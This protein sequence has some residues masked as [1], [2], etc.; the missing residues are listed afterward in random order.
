MTT[1]ANWY[2]AHQ[3]S[4]KRSEGKS[5]VGLVAY[6]TGQTLKDERSGTWC[7]RN[8]PGEV[9]A[10]G[11]VAPLNAPSRFTA[12]DK[13]SKIWNEIESSETRVNSIVAV[14]WNVAGSREFSETDHRVVAREIAKGLSQRYGVIVTFGI[15]KPTD[16]GDDRNW[17]YH[18]GH[19]MR[20]VGPDGIGEKAREIIAK[21]T[22]T[23]E[24]RWARGMIADALNTRLAKIGS[25][26]RVTHLSYAER[27][28]VQEPTKHLG[29]KQNMAELKGMLTPIGNH[30]REARERNEAYGA[31]QKTLGHAKANLEAQIHDL[32][33]ERLKRMRQGVHK[34]EV[35]EQQWNERDNAVRASLAEMA[36]SRESIAAFDHEYEEEQKRIAR[37]AASRSEETQ[38]RANRGDIPDANDRWAKAMHDSYN[39][40]VKPEESMAQAVGLEAEQFRKE[41]NAAREA[42]AKETDPAKKKMLEYGRQIAACDYMAIGAERCA[43]IAGF[44]VGKPDNEISNRDRDR[45]EQWREIGSKLR[46]D[47]TDL[48]ET[49]DK[50]VYE[51]V[52]AF[53]KDQSRGWQSMP[54]QWTQRTEE[55]DQFFGLGDQ[56]RPEYESR[57]AFRRD[58]PPQVEESRDQHPRETDVK[59]PSVAAQRGDTEERTDA[60][61]EKETREDT[62]FDQ[63]LAQH[64]RE[65]MQEVGRSRG[66]G[67]SR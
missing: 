6:I 47:R 43:S 53:L 18:F 58:L 54:N 60:K 52:E 16:H 32:T 11:T 9:L 34:V 62:T 59:Q 23:Q 1:T 39:P 37:T 14:H 48:K 29:N 42:E 57:P 5:A 25:N 17:H 3:D 35:P 41:Q 40:R 26:E 24:T 65:S 63:E 51:N 45:A 50:G 10:W 13:L 15:H 36:K 22:F 4:V 2:H 28:I 61:A 66:G 64:Y 27:G 12:K 21:Q 55:K 7:S 20:R 38:I 46:E 33:I 31:V 56:G 67:M 30:N 44:I 19:N 8:H 49:L